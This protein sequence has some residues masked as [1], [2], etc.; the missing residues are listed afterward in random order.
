MTIKKPLYWLIALIFTVTTLSIGCGLAY[1]TP[2]EYQLNPPLTSSTTE[3]I[4]SALIYDAGVFQNASDS[5]ETTAP[6]VISFDPADDATGVAT[7]VNGR[8]TVV[9]P[10]LPDCL[11]HNH[12]HCH[13]VGV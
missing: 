3:W 7:D 10:N 6:T 8:V 4:P 13:V 2:A 1:A 12:K 5:I 11:K 9:S